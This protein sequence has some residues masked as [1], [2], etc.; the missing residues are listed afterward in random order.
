MDNQDPRDALTSR[1]TIADVGLSCATCFYW[2]TSPPAG[3][4]LGRCLRNPPQSIAAT[5]GKVVS[6]FPLCR[7]DDVCGEWESDQEPPARLQ[8]AEVAGELGDEVG[9]LDAGVADLQWPVPAHRCHVVVPHPDDPSRSIP[10]GSL[11]PCLRHDV[12]DGAREP[13]KDGTGVDV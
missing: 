13:L 10:C 2:H 8:L 11:N 6:G 1:V 9:G 5:T 12:V 3:A 7:G 4:L